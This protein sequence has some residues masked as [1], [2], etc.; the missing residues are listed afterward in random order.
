METTKEQA[1]K[2]EAAGYSFEYPGFWNKDVGSYSLTISDRIVVPSSNNVFAEHFEVQVMKDEGATFVAG[3][4]TDTV[5]AA[6]QMADE[7]L[8]GQV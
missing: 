1:A 2:L 5:E 3:G 6:M 8:R 7:I 4:A